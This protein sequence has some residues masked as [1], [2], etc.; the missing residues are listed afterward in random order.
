MG[1]K[2]METKIKVGDK[3]SDQS[4][5][6]DM[7]KVVSIQEDKCTLEWYRY[8]PDKDREKWDTFTVSIEYMK[9]EI[10]NNIL[11]KY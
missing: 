3:F 9:R 5:G 10:E 4:S 6:R 2:T 7:Y 8:F 1:V 11:V